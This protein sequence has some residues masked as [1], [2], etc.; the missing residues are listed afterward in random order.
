MPAAASVRND[1]AT[2][3]YELEVDGHVAFI[4][5]ARSGDVLRLVHTEVPP[6]LGGR[7]V[8][9]ALVRGALEDIR[10]QGQK[11]VVMCAF[12]RGFMLKNPD[13]NDLLA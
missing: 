1:T 4:Q 11:I 10:R 12:V 8:G 7:G 2:S 5:Y 13:F 9:T 3:R 6:E